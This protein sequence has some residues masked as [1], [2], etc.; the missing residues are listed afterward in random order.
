MRNI[1]LHLMFDGTNYHGFQRQKNGIT[2]QS[3]LEDAV[4]AITGEHVPVIGCSRTDAGVHAENYVAMFDTTC[5]IPALLFPKALNSALPNDIRCMNAWEAKE[6]FHPI[7]SAIE[8]T[9][10]YTIVNR[11]VEDVFRR[12]YAWFYPRPLAVEDMRRAAA[13]FL[14]E[15]DFSAFMAA[16]STAKTTVRHVKKL[17]IEETDGILRISICA[18]GFLYNMVRIIVGTLVCVGN[19]RF[20][21][22]DVSKILESGDRRRAGMTAPPQGLR[23]FEIVYPEMTI[24]PTSKEK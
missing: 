23:L 7:F 12:A 5:R 13:C 22:E 18:D 20:A 21:I 11:R 3:Q 17:D 9:Y 10:I 2:I 8:K 19:G 6:G 24:G 16:G 15:H 1:A 4:F 14:G